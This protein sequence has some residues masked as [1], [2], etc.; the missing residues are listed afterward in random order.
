MKFRKSLR[1]RIILACIMFSLVVCFTFGFILIKTIKINSDEQYDWHIQK[2]LHHLKTQYLQDKIGFKTTTRGTVLIGNEMQV[3]DQV[4]QMIQGK[5]KTPKLGSFEELHCRRT[6]HFK[7]KNYGFFRYRSE[8]RKIDIRRLSL[9]ADEDKDLYYIIDITGFNKTDNHGVHIILKMFSVAILIIIV[10][11]FFTGMYLVKKVMHPL[12]HL[13]SNVDLIDAGQYESNPTEYYE[14]EIGYLAKT[15]DS[16]VSRTASFV[17]RERA[18]S[19]DASHELRTPVASSQ[20]AL[21][22]AYVLV[23]EEDTKLK[24]LLDRIKRANKNMTHLIESFLVLGRETSNSLEGEEFSLK[25]LAL[26]SLE[27][28]R[29]KQVNQDVICDVKI[30][31]DL[32][33]ETNKNLL[34]IVLDNLVRNSF[35]HTDEGSITIIGDKSFVKV[36]DTGRGFDT[37]AEAGIGLNIVKRICDQQNWQFDIQS[38]VDQG[39]QIEIHFSNK[40]D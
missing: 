40:T 29:Y 11:I 10:F 1:F 15:I 3:L 25:E 23:G 28:N 39:T 6:H 14:D 34:S 22:V 26:N 17:K 7:K 31:K 16:F 37:D 21:D 13:A 18:F 12:T 8:H 20:A 9:G 2:E 35:E 32:M 38:V 27:R 36:N 5:N 19:R 4:N 24:S 33:I 30:S